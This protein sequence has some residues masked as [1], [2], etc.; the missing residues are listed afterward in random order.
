MFKHFEQDL[1]PEDSIAA[2]PGSEVAG[3][4]GDGSPCERAAPVSE[5]SAEVQSEPRR[6]LPLATEG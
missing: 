4:D 2:D 6:V 3:S 1:E 5:D